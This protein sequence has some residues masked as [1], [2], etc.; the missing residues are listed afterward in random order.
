M[1]FLQVN[2]LADSVEDGRGIM[3]IKIIRGKVKR[4]EYDLSEH[5]HKER[6]EEQ[7]TKELESRV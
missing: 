2:K 1:F 4:K 3:D 6:R 5:A 7:I